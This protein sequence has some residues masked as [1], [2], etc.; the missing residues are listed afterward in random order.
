MADINSISCQ[1]VSCNN[2]TRPRYVVMTTTLCLVSQ[3]S[4]FFRNE[5]LHTDYDR[6]KSVQHF[7]WFIRVLP[8]CYYI[9]MLDRHSKAFENLNRTIVNYNLL[10]CYTKSI[11]LH[12][13][14][15]RI[16]QT[17]FLECEQILKSSYCL[18]QPQNSLKWSWVFSKLSTNQI[19]NMFLQVQL[20]A[21][22]PVSTVVGN[23]SSLLLDL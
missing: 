20:L 23:V 6:F 19:P 17:Q 14:D 13:F 3:N 2:R 18:V 7:L 4:P 10:Y 9:N 1:Y 21:L 8:L 12:W 15:K 5:P 16:I 11:L 22:I